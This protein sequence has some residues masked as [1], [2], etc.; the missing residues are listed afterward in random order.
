VEK[1]EDPAKNFNLEKLYKDDN[2][3]VLE[4]I[5]SDSFKPASFQS[6]AKSK[7]VVDLEKDKILIPTSSS[8]IEDESLIHP[9]FL[10]DD[11]KR[12]DKWIKKLYVYRNNS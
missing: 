12:V 10:G 11:S 8:A 1:K 5:E 7:I 4:E 2:S 3:K 9:D 6:Q